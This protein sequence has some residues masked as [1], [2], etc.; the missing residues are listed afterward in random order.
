MLIGH[1]ARFRHCRSGEGGIPQNVDILVYQGLHGD[2]VHAT[3]EVVDI[4]Q[5]GLHRDV[6][7]PMRRHDVEHITRHTIARFSGEPTALHIH[8]GDHHIGP[9]FN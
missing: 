7:R 3:P 8:L 4:H 5:A 9:V 6:T 1:M 2:P